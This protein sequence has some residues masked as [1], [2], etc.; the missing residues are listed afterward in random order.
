[1]KNR[2]WAE[3]Y[4]EEMYVLLYILRTEEEGEVFD[5]VLPDPVID[6]KVDWEEVLQYDLDIEDIDLDDAED[7]EFLEEL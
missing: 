2:Q 3:D 4:F 6:D 7:I 1:M 5:F